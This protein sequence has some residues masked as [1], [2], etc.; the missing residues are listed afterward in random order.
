MLGYET[1]ADMLGRKLDDFV[2]PEELADH[3]LQMTERKL[4]RSSSY[5][6]RFRNKNGDVIWCDV[7]GTPLFDDNM[8]FAGS[9]GMMTDITERKKAEETIKKNEAELNEAQRIGHFGHFDWDART[10]TIKWSDEYYHIYGFT[11]GQKPPGYEDHLK[12]YT[13]E[14]AARLDAAVKNSM[15]TG[16]PYAVDLEHVRPDGIHKWITA[17]GEVKR[18]EHG[19][20]IGLRGTAQDITERK[21]AELEREQFFRFFNLSTDIM[22]IADPKG[23]FK[24]VNPTCLH[25]LGYSEDELLAKPFIDF[26][27]PDDKQPTLD[28]MVR[29]MQT[30]SSLNFENR[31]IC[32]DGKA[33]WFSWRANFNKDEGITYATARDVTE[34]KKAELDLTHANRALRM[35]S[36]INQALIRIAEEATLLHEA[37]RIA[38]ETGGYSL[39]WVGYAEHDEAKTV[40]PVAQAGLVEGYADEAHITW[41][42]TERGR[43]PTGLAIRTGIVQLTHDIPSDPTMAPWQDAAAKRGYK[44]SIALPLIHEGVT[45]GS[46]NIYSSEPNAFSDEEVKILE[47]MAGD[48]SFGINDLRLRMKQK[49]EEDHIVELNVVRSKFINIISHQLGTPL[50][51]VNW[52]L[53]MLL[54]GDFGKLDEVQ[55]KFL[56][57]THA[58]SIE[59][60]HRINYLLTAIDIEERRV[61]YEAEDTIL[62]NICAGVVQDMAKKAELKNLSFVYTP[63]KNDMPTIYADGK[64]IRMVF[65]ALIEN[66][67][68][69]TKNGGNISMALQSDGNVAR[70]EITDT[71]VG[72]PQPEQHHIFDRFFRASNA[73]IMQPDAFGLGLF[74][75]KNFVE[76]LGGTITF[77]SKEGEGSTFVLEIP[78]KK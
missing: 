5:E 59:I 45:F 58:A 41:A 15:K 30:G 17:N 35:I 13:P 36:N 21:N 66:A 68:V 54:N 18:D 7:S 49:Q 23:A 64:K 32:K 31:Y 22:V 67:I 26:V 20:I 4:G 57:A 48:L 33:L 52:N 69:Y 19:T 76:Q 72:V 56:Q 6:R 63:P 62:P 14:S 46:L 1:E 34:R 47:E 61:T 11:P 2:V 29:Q 28:E 37:C 53:E 25:V 73:A 43:G 12:T 40:R 10:D 42:D 8:Q 50:T 44:S 71:G 24:R 70:F 16:E 78:L 39:A 38:V 9:F 51:A 60:T 55:L 65:S 27:H 75:A 74:I 3:E 77:T